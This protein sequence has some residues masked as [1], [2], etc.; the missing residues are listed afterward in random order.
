MVTINAGENDLYVCDVINI[1]AGKSYLYVSITAGT[2]DAY[3]FNG[4]DIHARENSRICL[5]RYQYHC[6]Y[7]QLKTL[8]CNQY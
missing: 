6:S 4:Y 3:V 7:L 2:T 8:W 5:W 1:T